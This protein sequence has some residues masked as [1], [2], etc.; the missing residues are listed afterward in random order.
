MPFAMA[1]GFSASRRM[2]TDLVT[3]DLAGRLARLTLDRA[4]RGN[5]ITSD[6]LLTIVEACE[7]IAA[8]DI[9]VVVLAGSGPTFSVGFDLDEIE[10]GG[11]SDGAHAGARAVEALLDLEAVTVAALRGWV[12]GGGAALA[13]ACDLRVGDST[14]VVRIPEVPLGIPLGWGAMPLLV[15]ELGPSAAKDLVMTGRDMRAEEA[16]Q[17]GLLTRL[18]A[19]GELDEAVDALAARLL[20]VPVGP[21]RSTKRQANLAAAV[22]R[23]GDADALLLIEAVGSPEFGEMFARYLARV[24]PEEGTSGR[25]G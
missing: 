16:H 22:T 18:V 3:L 7:E 4:E 23:T 25:P 17:R 21:L 5:A 19:G 15:A 8:V 14:T 20:E 13:A 12:V 9:D 1:I 10:S 2:A 24:R 6:M 11:T